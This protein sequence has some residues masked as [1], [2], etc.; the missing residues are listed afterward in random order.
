LVLSLRL[1]L[2]LPNSLLT[3]GSLT[4]NPCVILMP[5]TRASRFIKLNFSYLRT[6][7]MFRENPRL[8]SS[9][10]H[11]LIYKPVPSSPSGTNSL[12]SAANPNVLSSTLCTR[13][14]Q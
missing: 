5:L 8:Q 3:S 6:R 7:E 10:F 11:S 13:T 4:T 1:G 12:L 9:S 14:H 2:G